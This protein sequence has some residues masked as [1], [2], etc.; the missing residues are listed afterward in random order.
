MKTTNMTPSA[1]LLTGKVR[2]AALLACS[3]ERI[4]S[5]HEAE[6]AARTAGAL[7]RADGMDL[8]VLW[9]GVPEL[10]A[11]PLAWNSVVDGW[12]GA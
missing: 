1:L 7:C 9:E 8:D 4:G 10:H 12:H 2:K 3:A 5:E 11:A 6:Q